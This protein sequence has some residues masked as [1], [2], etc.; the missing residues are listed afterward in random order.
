MSTEL[1]DATSHIAVATGTCVMIQDAQIVYA[2]PLRTA[3][4]AAG[5]MVLLSPTDF[6]DLSRHVGKAVGR[7]H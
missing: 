4:D 1:F 2:G 6:A 3:P 5:R 7:Q